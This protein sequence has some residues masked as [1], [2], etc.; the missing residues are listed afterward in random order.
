VRRS[1]PVADD[2]QNCRKP[3]CFFK[4]SES[5]Y[6]SY[7]MNRLEYFMASFDSALAELAAKVDAVLAVIADDSAALD[8]ARRA[9]ADAVALADRVFAD[10]AADDAVQDEARAASL[11]DISAKLDA[12]LNPP[13]GDPSN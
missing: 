1:R 3:V 10:D 8:A 7:R 5:R 11:S 4:K 9:A 12:V 13:A 2:G 6:L